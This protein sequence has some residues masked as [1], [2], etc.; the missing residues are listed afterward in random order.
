MALKVA[1]IM[2]GTSFERDF[3]LKSGKRIA[4]DLQSLGYEVLPLDANDA[5]VE[6]LRAEKPDVA[7]IAMHG[8]GGEDGTVQELLEF[9]QIPYVGS[10]SDACRASWNKVDLARSF[11]AYFAEENELVTPQGFCLTDVAFR[12]MGAAGAL[13]LVGERLGFPVCVKPA[14]G[15]S[16]LG[17]AR[18]DRQED[19]GEAILGALA[20]DDKVIIEEWIEGVELAVSVMGSEDEVS[21]MPAVE[22]A[23]KHGFFNTEARLDEA[24]VDYYTPVRDASLGDTP[25]AVEEARHEISY[26]AID[27]FEALGCRDLARVDMIYRDGVAYITDVKVAPGL[28]YMSLL[29][30]SAKACGIDMAELLGQLVEDAAERGC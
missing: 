26:A 2:G 6:T 22:I 24:L 14:C 15:G 20:F 11:D 23:P 30:M 10:T 3:S 18:V 16:A 9:L 1:V 4:D 12:S 19:L 8:L 27:V 13:D 25:E 28:S 17:V 29:P 7:F 5:L 21:V